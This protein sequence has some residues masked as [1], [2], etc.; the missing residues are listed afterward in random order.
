M[1]AQAARLK[2]EGIICKR[3]GRPYVA[4]RGNDWLKVK[5]S[6][7]EEFVVGGFTKPSGSRGGFGALLLGYYDERRQL[8]HAG[9]VGA[10]F[11]ERTLKDMHARMKKLTRKTPPFAGRERIGASRDVTWIEPKIVVQTRF[12]NW[13]DEGLLRQPVFLGIREDK[14]AREVTRESAARPEPGQEFT[15]MTKHRSDSRRA[16]LK[17]AAAK[18]SARDDDALPA[19]IAGV[20]LSHPDKVLYADNGVTKHDLAHYYEQVAER[21]LPHVRDRLLSLV[22]C[23]A[24]SGKTCF[25]QKHPGEGNSPR[26]IR[27]DV[28]EHGKT[29]HYLA[30]DDVG[31]LVAL[32]QMA[33]LEIHCWGSKRDDPDKPDRLVIDLDP[34]PGVAWKQI[35]EAVR[36]VRQVLEA[37]DLE[38]FVKTSGGKGL[39]VVTP[40]RRGSSWAEVKSFSKAVAEHL[41]MAAP[42]KYV[43]T[44]SKAARRGRIYIDYLRNDRGATAIAPYSTRARAGATVSMPLAWD[45]LTARMRPD[46]FNIRN[47][48]TRLNRLAR[49]PW[50]AMFKTRQSITASMLKKLQTGERLF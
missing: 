50:A 38:S 19:T 9:R 29:E 28:E 7:H 11:D 41:A 42:E 48:I 10:G 49:D 20:A 22:R 2:L 21:M 30:I 27:V 26:L 12:S 35:A 34:D 43:S 32:V 47:A 37:L 16:A 36:D 40:L 18:S 3:R 17:S 24:G 25:F 33:V 15:P 31:G 8:I 5:C 45:E 13:T 4:G 23:P 46:H 14:P 1:F 44:M 39:H 6:L